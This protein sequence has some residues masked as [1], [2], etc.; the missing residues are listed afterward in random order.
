MQFRTSLRSFRTLME[1]DKKSYIAAANEV[2]SGLSRSA[3]GEGLL[4]GSHLWLRVC[5]YGLRVYSQALRLAAVGVL[6]VKLT[7]RSAEELKVGVR[8]ATEA[9]TPS[10]TRMALS[11][12][13]GFSL[14]NDTMKTVGLYTCPP[15]LSGSSP[16]AVPELPAAGARASVHMR[17]GMRDVRLGVREPGHLD[18]P[19]TPD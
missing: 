17:G 3:P 8:A 2:G 5:S 15:G 7:V 12:F 6:D 18:M 13:R 11:R 1:R 9:R 14:R 10:G 4:F 16:P 19:G